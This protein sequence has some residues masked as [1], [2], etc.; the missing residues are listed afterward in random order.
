MAKSNPKATPKKGL[1]KGFAGKGKFTPKGK[2]FN[3]TLRTPASAGK[4]KTPLSASA[5]RFKRAAGNP[6]F[7]KKTPQRFQIKGKR[8]AKFI[9]AAF[10]KR[11]PQVKRKRL[12]GLIFMCNSSTKQDCFKSKIF[13]LPEGKID[14]VENVYPGMKLFLF[15]ADSRV[16]YGVYEAVSQ[17]GMDINPRAF[18]AGSFP[19][20]VRYRIL[21]KCAPLPEDQFKHA[22]KENY[23]G[24][25]RF[26][27]ELGMNQ[28]RRLLDMFGFVEN[29]ARPKVIAQPM[30]QMVAKPVGM[31]RPMRGGYE[32]ES[33]PLFHDPRGD[34]RVPMEPIYKPR[35]Y[36][37][38]APVALPSYSSSSLLSDMELRR[39]QPPMEQA[40]DLYS[41]GS[42]DDLL[43]TAYSR[44]LLR[45]SLGHLG[46]ES[47]L[48]EREALL[49][50]RLPSYQYDL[51]RRSYALDALL[52][53]R[54]AALSRSRAQD[55]LLTR[56]MDYLRGGLPR[57]S[58]SYGGGSLY[59]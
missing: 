9:A 27:F 35:H 44:P 32:M 29:D 18:R 59:Y 48:L 6:K 52:D 50:S 7:A 40:A 37:E 23:F 45:S 8:D 36:P 41:L 51:D 16:L 26:K 58:S 34:G 56:Q 24:N 20:Q 38:V 15:D 33:G 12:A 2:K 13:G 39:F 25:N 30:L 47:D 5:G 57:S 43:A 53:P 3:K 42:R 1:K 46:L 10:S 4:F 31:R 54:A 11:A 17:G 22:I 21:R 55:D 14:V 28:V 19:A 49:R